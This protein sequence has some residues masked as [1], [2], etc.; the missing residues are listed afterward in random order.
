MLM[1]CS[2]ER[3]G[4][5]AQREWTNAHRDRGRS[6]RLLRGHPQSSQEIAILVDP[7]RY[8]IRG[9]ILF[10]QG[11]GAGDDDNISTAHI[12]VECDIG[13]PFKICKTTPIGSTVGQK[14]G[15]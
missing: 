12:K 14:I 11:C 10:A 13:V 4:S 3:I 6:S 7:L 5:I 8:L 2:L 15:L 1:P 9:Q